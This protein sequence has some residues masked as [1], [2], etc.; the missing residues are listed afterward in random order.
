MAVMAPKQAAWEAE[1]E[2]GVGFARAAGGGFAR[3]TK[4]ARRRVAGLGT[5]GLAPPSWGSWP[6]SR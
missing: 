2:K 4:V 3:G 5:A 6:V 1:R